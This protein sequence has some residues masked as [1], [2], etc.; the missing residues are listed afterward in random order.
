[1]NI[2][3]Q[4]PLILPRMQDQKS[5]TRRWLSFSEWGTECVSLVFGYKGSQYIRKGQRYTNVNILQ[6]AVGCLNGTINRKAQIPEPEIATARLSET[7]EIPRVDR[8]GCGFGPPRCSGS[9]F[10]TGLEQN[11]MA[12]A[13]RTWT[14]DGLPGPIANTNPINDCF[15][16]HL[17]PEYS[18]GSECNTVYTE[19]PIFVESLPGSSS[20]SLLCLL[21]HLH[22][23]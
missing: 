14:A 5:L 13:V 16:K 20:R 9:G 1:M 19:P 8:H 17:V 23:E 12:F 21:F 4:L 11:W 6:L 18:H 3:I 10:C 15:W 2:C 7:H 22:I